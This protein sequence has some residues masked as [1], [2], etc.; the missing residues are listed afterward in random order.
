M[1]RRAV[2]Q[3]D[4]TLRALDRQPGAETT[5]ALTTR[6]LALCQELHTAL[7]ASRDEAIVRLSA[8]GWSLQDVATIV[9]L[10]RG[11]VH[12]ILLRQRELAA[13]GPPGDAAGATPTS[14]DQG[15]Q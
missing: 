13:Q 12:Q 2:A 3:L 8:A 9:C 5:A 15:V 4:A 1:D 6:A 11:R 10:T 7:T 14:S